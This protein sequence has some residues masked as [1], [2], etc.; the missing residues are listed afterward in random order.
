[1]LATHHISSMLKRTI[2]T[3]AL[4]AFARLAS[5]VSIDSRTLDEI[6]Q[7]AQREHGVLNVYFGG[8]CKSNKVD[9]PSSSEF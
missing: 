1:M 7:A 2:S 8:S 5:A 9:I 3:C 6:Y 4:L